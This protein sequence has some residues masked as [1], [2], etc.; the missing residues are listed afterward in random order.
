MRALFTV[1]TICLLAGATAAMPRVPYP[2][3]TEI[4]AL[5]A[6]LTDKDLPGLV[7]YENLV[8]LTIEGRYSGAW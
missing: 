5:K 7:G 3:T 6:N 2:P 4:R 1:T 8:S